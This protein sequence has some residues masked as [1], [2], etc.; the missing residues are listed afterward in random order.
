MDNA[1]GI[2]G[3]AK[4]AGKLEIGEESVSTA[5][6]QNRARLIMSANDASASSREHA[7]N[8][9]ASGGTVMIVLPYGKEELGALLGRGSPGI[10]ALTDLG[11][12]LSLTDKLAAAHPQEY[13]GA[14]AALKKKKT[15]RDERKAAAGSASGNPAKRRTK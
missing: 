6:R 7:E 13:D 8:L 1:A 12:A 3:L 9:A 10:I 5:V 2:L 15:R 4:K 14:A 11:M